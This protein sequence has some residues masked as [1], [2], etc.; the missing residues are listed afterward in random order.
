MNAIA[1]NELKP[2]C[3]VRPRA[4]GQGRSEAQKNRA[5]RPL[6]FECD[7]HAPDA[8]SGPPRDDRRA[9][10]PPHKLKPGAHPT[11]EIRN[12]TTAFEARGPKIWTTCR[13]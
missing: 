5:G 3:A 13:R 1:N 2:I 4:P 12:G 6:S 7:R 10:G 11:K 9:P 8:N